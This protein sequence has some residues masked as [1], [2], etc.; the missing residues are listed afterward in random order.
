MTYRTLREAQVLRDNSNHTL[1][2]NRT[3]KEGGMYFSEARNVTIAGRFWLGYVAF[4]VT[5]LVL[6]TW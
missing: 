4:I 6:L 1:R 2:F 3:T 5:C